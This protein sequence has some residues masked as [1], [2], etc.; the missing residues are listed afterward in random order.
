MREFFFKDD[1]LN[2]PP[3]IRATARVLAFASFAF[4]LV[5]SV[6]FLF[7]D[8]PPLPYAGALMFIVIADIFFHYFL[9]GE[10]VRNM[11][12]TGKINTA[13]YVSPKTRMV[14]RV[15]YGRVFE[16]G[17]DFSLN[18][19]LYAVGERGIRSALKRL[20]VD[21]DEFAE[22]IAEKLK[23]TTVSSDVSSADIQGEMEIIMR[24]AAKEADRAGENEITAADIFLAILSSGGADARKIFGVFGIDENSLRVAL[25]FSRVVSRMPVYNVKKFSDWFSPKSRRL[26][27]GGIISRKSP[28]LSEFSSDIT[29]AASG[30]K[31]GFMVGHQAEYQDL[32]RVMVRP[33][34]AGAVLVGE[35]GIGKETI[36]DHLAYAIIRDNVPKVLFDKCVYRLNLRSFL[37]GSEEAVAKR[38]EFAFRE[39]ISAGNAIIHISQAEDL[40]DLPIGRIF[41]AAAQSAVG[42]GKVRFIISEEPGQWEKIEKIGWFKNFKPINIMEL[43]DEQAEEY[44]AYVGSLIEK[45]WS[46][47]I[48]TSAIRRAVSLAKKHGDGPLPS[49]AQKI[50]EAA[51]EEAKMKDGDEI[52]SIEVM[53]GALRLAKNK[54]RREAA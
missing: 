7:S 13:D 45:K 29:R 22:K 34:N 24:A 14:L 2:L 12:K 42:G 5:A 19:S 49:S 10:S 32:M 18:F 44:L 46:I 48:K 39:V 6:I 21:P 1:Y 9:P 20:D 4:F 28:A 37:E 26:L 36:V 35:S 3:S 30:G 16:F 41:S 27:S 54:D 40:L 43:S 8:I 47:V 50:I 23:G 33:E 25:I 31:V 38:I 52:G 11:P 53:A 51:L 17:E 15:I